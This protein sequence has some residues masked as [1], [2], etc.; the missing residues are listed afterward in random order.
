MTEFSGV[1]HLRIAASLASIDDGISK[2]YLVGEKML[3][4]AHY[5][6][7]QSPGDNDTMYSGYCFDL[8][9]FAGRGGNSVPWM[10]PLLDGD[11]TIDPDIRFGSAHQD[12]FHMAYCD[13]SV[14]LVNYEVD[15]ETHF[16]AG[17][18]RD[19]GERLDSLH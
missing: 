17:H 16:R 15:P 7:G 10:P 19:Q 13:G 4:P 1:S 5:E 2:T 18:R 12:G 3:D 14:R 11:E 9:R 6:D 8:H